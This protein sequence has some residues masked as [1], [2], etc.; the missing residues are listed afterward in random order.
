MKAAGAGIC[1]PALHLSKG[2]G[3]IQHGNNG[4]FSS[5]FNAIPEH[6]QEEAR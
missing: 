3:K 4:R 5:N 6:H 2:V 1:Q